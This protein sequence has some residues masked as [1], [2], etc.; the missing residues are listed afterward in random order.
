MN[1]IRVDMNKLQVHLD[2]VPSV[3][4][5]LGGRALIAKI[6]LEEVPPKC[7]ALGP[8]NKLILAP[9]LLGGQGLARP[10]EYQLVGK[11]H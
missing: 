7:D 4:E 2:S 1:I 3:Y 9:G 11:A 6:L 10:V 5:R 8:H